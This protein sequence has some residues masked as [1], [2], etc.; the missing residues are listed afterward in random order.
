LRDRGVS[1][2][3]SVFLFSVVVA[4]LDLIAIAVDGDDL[5]VHEDARFRNVVVGGNDSDGPFLG[6]DGK[7]E[8]QHERG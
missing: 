5:G 7:R 6:E 4:D 1:A 3:A 2:R 8:G